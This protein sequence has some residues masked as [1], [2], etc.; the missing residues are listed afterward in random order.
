MKNRE[1][2]MFPA[3]VSLAGKK[4]YVIGG[5][6]IAE[7]RVRTLS[8]FAEDVTVIAPEI[9]EPLREVLEEE[10]YSSIEIPYE[11]SLIEDG[12]MVLACTSDSAVN[13][14]IWKDCRA[15]GIPVNHCGD[16]NRCDFHFPGVICRDEI[17]VGINAG[18]KDHRKV[19]IVRRQLKDFLDSASAAQADME[20]G[21]EKGERK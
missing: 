21:R 10:Q 19:K 5:G 12:D 16:K 8:C 2:R 3:F 7:R 4:I 20:P 18:G 13:D 6:R 14:L 15:L 11:S 9:S 1:N 17:T